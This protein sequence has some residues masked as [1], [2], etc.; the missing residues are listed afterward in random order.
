MTQKRSANK[1]SGDLITRF[2]KY[3]VLVSTSR[4]NFCL[5]FLFIG[6]V[7]SAMNQDEVIC[8]HHCRNSSERTRVRI[9][10]LA[11]LDHVEIEVND[12]M[13]YLYSHR[14]S[15]QFLTNFEKFCAPSLIRCNVLLCIEYLNVI[16]ILWIVRFGK[17]P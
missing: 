17:R 13:N 11:V 8:I 1:V 5:F 15:C 2:S 12:R 3:Q 9:F 6:I 14:A 7:E 10:G 16:S 4:E